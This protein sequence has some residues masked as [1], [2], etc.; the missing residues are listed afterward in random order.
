MKSIIW[1]ESIEAFRRN[2]IYIPV[3]IFLAIFLEVFPIVQI[4][5]SESI[6]KS[7]NKLCFKPY[8]DL[9][10]FNNH[11]NDRNEYFS[12]IPL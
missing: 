8:T 4:I 3:A 11:C 6:E 5:N 12:Q 9:F 2:R 7:S 10:S 1:K